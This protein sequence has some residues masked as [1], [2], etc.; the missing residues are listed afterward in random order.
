M[1][2]DA[3]RNTLG[4]SGSAEQ[5]RKL[6]VEH[7][8]MLAQIVSAATIVGSVVYLSLQVDENTKQLRSQSHFNAVSLGQRPIE[9]MIQS[10]GLANVVYVCNAT[11][12]AV[13][14]DDWDRCL[15]YNLMIFNAFEYWY[16]Q[17][18]DGAIPSYLWIGADNYWRY[19]IERKPGLGRFWSEYQS[20]FG[21]PFRSYI[22]QQF[23]NRP[24]GK[25]EMM[26]GRL[27]CPRQYV[28]L[29]SNGEI[30]P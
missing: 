3:R 29:G 10:P 20:F 8:T 25:C 6:R 4:C 30:H 1:D 5:G 21:D 13:S 9:M 16:Y 15:N 27:S 22:S 17:N 23:A 26:Q 18:R 2:S 14:A 7:W 12:D 19:L 28:P 11:P 24:T